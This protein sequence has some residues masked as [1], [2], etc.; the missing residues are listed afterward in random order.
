[1]WSFVLTFHYFYE[2]QSDEYVREAVE[3]A[4][5]IVH[6]AL[7]SLEFQPEKGW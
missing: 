7:W 4:R 3:I 6:Y 1:M 5:A 2:R